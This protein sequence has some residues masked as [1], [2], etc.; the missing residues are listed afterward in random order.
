MEKV[1]LIWFIDLYTV[2]NNIEHRIVQGFGIPSLTIRKKNRIASHW[3]RDL[4]T[5]LQQS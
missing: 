2:W 3:N 5:K 4:G 1:E